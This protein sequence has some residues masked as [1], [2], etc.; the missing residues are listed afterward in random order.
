[1][2]KINR[3]HEAGDLDFPYRRNRNKKTRKNK[4]RSRRRAPWK[5]FFILISILLFF[6]LVGAG[7]Y[8]YPAFLYTDWSDNT[9]LVI[10]NERIGEGLT[11][12]KEREIY[13][14][15]EP[16]K[17]HLDPHFYWDEEEKTAIITTEDRLIKMKSEEANA[18]VN[19]EPMELE[20][21][22][23]EFDGDLFLP[24]IFLSDYYNL[25]I[26][27]HD[28][29]DTVV[30]D[31][32]AKDNAYRAMTTSEARLREGPH[33]REPILKTLN[34]GDHLR[35]ENPQEGWNLVRSE[36]G[37]T[38]YLRQDDFSVLEPYYLAAEEGGSGA[39]SHEEPAVS[40]SPEHPI[41]LVWEFAYLDTDIE[42]IGDLGPTQV[43]SPTWFHLSDAEGSL[44]NMADPE[45]VNWAHERGYQVWGLVTNDFEP[46]RTAE[47]LSSSS[48]RQNLIRKLL[49]KAQIYELDGL[50]IDFENFHAD[51]RDEFTQ[52]IRELSALCQ[53]EGLVLSVDVTMISNSQYYSRCYDRAALAEVVDYVAL[54]AYDEHWAASPVAGSV[55]SLPWVER[56]LRR[57]LKEVPPEQLLLGVP[58]YTRLWEIKENEDGEQ[59]VSSR[60]L[61][62]HQ[63]EQ[64]LEE[65]G[66]E[67][68]MDKDTGQYYA[69]YEENDKT[70]RVW[71]ENEASMEQR[72]ELVNEYELAGLA[73]WRRG[74]ERPEIW[75]VI[76]ETLEK[77]PEN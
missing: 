37:V 2:D 71:L 61:Y 29:T 67:P 9:V 31:R 14:H 16:L 53:K 5:T 23:Q 47:L 32:P 30:I 6:S 76:E 12:P 49:A 75:D 3:N 39:P 59:E 25:E 70:Y 72:V 62:M 74:F 26:E 18:E 63:I 64:I 68:E 34:E 13:L 20:F 15:V 4:E 60:A 45:Y 56:G 7:I 35:V 38:G 50:N 19:F 36:E 28:Q 40:L 1:L 65:R 22:L 44:R 77:H 51:Y 55:A 21:P 11:I 52:F 57:V 42:E 46:E 43:V 54:M 17:D 73:A 10:G 24:M 8:F 41:S 58:F 27:Y 69:E 33:L 66:V 48:N